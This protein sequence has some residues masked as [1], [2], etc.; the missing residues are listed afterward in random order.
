M[1]IV[2]INTNKSYNHFQYSRKLH[3]QGHGDHVYTAC[4]SP[5]CKQAPLTILVGGIWGIILEKP[6]TIDQ[7]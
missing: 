5:S 2:T 6:C 7:S 4:F 1:K 3:K